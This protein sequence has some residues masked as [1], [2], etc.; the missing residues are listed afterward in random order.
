M[1][2]YPAD[3]L[4]AFDQLSQMLDSAVSQDIPRIMGRLEELKV[5]LSIRLSAIPMQQ[6]S[7]GDRVHAQERYLT[8]QEVVARYP[9]TAK[10]LYRHKRNL[11]HSQPTRKT[12]LFPERRFSNW[13]ANQKRH[14]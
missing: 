8:V 12:L 11:P 7:V 3:L 6:P 5:K 1:A 2:Q 9:V 4:A 10:W 14:D 13:W